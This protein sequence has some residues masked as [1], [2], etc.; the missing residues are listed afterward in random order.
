MRFL[1]RRSHLH[2]LDAF[3]NVS[4]LLLESQEERVVARR[5]L[6]QCLC[7]AF[8]VVHVEVTVVFKWYEFSC[9]RR[10]RVAQVVTVH[11]TVRFYP[12]CPSPSKPPVPQMLQVGNA[13]NSRQNMDCDLSKKAETDSE[14]GVPDQKLP[15]RIC[16]LCGHKGRKADKRRLANTQFSVLSCDHVRLRLRLFQTFCLNTLP[17]TFGE[18]F[19][20]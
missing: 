6:K 5:I 15:T 16:T 18:Y 8:V 14:Y 1:V 12:V 17:F 13:E 10:H 11:G 2:P 9:F 4:N 19:C 7:R 20:A 3:S